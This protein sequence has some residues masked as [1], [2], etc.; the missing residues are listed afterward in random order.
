MSMKKIIPV[1]FVLSVAVLVLLHKEQS[2][3]MEN[4]STIGTNNLI[5][6]MIKD[7]NGEYQ[8]STTDTFPVGMSLNEELSYC[9][10]GTEIGYDSLLGNVSITGIGSDECY[11]YFDMEVLGR[12]I[13][14]HNGG[15]DAIESK[16][17]PNFSTIAD[18]DEGMYSAEDNY[19]TSY[20]ILG[21]L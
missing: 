6:I 12:L 15:V 8:K 10:N 1:C 4:N 14:D 19:G 20:Y 7:S 9:L 18:T 3:S 11:I 16:E 21:G 17:V 5:S 13:L 2:Y